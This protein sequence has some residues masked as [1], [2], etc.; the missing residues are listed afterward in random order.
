M[1]SSLVPKPAGASSVQNQAAAQWENQAGAL[2]A[3]PR[4]QHCPRGATASPWS[5]FNA[6]QP[7]WL[8]E[9][10]CVMELPKEKQSMLRGSC[11]LPLPMTQGTVPDGAAGP[12][13][14]LALGFSVFPSTSGLSH[15]LKHCWKLMQERVISAFIL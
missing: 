6:A 9:S 7:V 15:G 5:A 2:K 1:L 3:W 13:Q 10:V 11:N 12:Q 4:Q 8:C 14:D